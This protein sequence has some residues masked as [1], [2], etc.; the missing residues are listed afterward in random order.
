MG[1]NRYWVTAPQLDSGEYD[2][3]SGQ[4]TPIPAKQSLASIAANGAGHILSSL[5][6]ARMSLDAGKTWSTFK[7]IAKAQ[8][9]SMFDSSTGV[10]ILPVSHAFTG[11]Q[12]L[13]STHDAGHSWTKVSS[14]PNTP[15]NIASI[16]ANDVQRRIICAFRNGDI[17]SA[18]LDGEWRREREVN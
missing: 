2:F 18:G 1:E 11:D 14:L 4:W 10:A 6:P 8:S 9:L 16:Q 5:L 15:C 13:Y 3:E 17:Y 12:D 7:P